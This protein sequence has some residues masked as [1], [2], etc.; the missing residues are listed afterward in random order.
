VRFTTA[1]RGYRMSEVDA[2][3]ERLADELDAARRETS[4]GLDTSQ[5]RPPAS[6]SRPQPAPQA[7][8]DREEGR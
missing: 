5:G 3:L 8:L 1:L 4:P 7:P 2:L 6:E